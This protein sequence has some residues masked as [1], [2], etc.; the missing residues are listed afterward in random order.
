MAVDDVNSTAA[1]VTD[2]GGTLEVGPAEVGPAG[3]L[4]VVRD[5]AG[6]RVLLWQAG[7]RLGAGLVNAPGAWNFSNLRTADPAAVRPFYETLFG[8]RFVDLPGSAGQWIQVPG[9]GQHLADTVDPDI[10]ERQATAPAGFADVV[11]G[12]E[13]AGSSPTPVWSVVFAVA[14]RD[15]SAA[16][17]QQLGGIVLATEDT[18]WTKTARVSDPQ[19][20]SFTLSQ[21][22]PPS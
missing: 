18:L 21:F 11:A 5:P 1:A 22:A 4:A 9:Y 10:F 14:D 12:V 16:T 17:A 2:A 19:G 15:A 8:W 13:P 20:G 7:Q 3:A 6:A